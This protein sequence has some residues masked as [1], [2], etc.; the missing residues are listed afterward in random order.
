GGCPAASPPPPR[1]GAS[2]VP[3]GQ[4]GRR[5]GGGQYGEAPCPHEHREVKGLQRPIGRGAAT[6][7]AP[8]GPGAEAV[9]TARRCLSGGVRAPACARHD[10]APAPPTWA[11]PRAACRP[12][13]HHQANQRRP[14]RLR[15]CP[16]TTHL[17]LPSSFR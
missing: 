9:N 14:R 16:G 10:L 2:R 13:P 6:S 17:S 11:G 15:G 12:H 1:R 8:R 3:R 5:E 4:R 7:P